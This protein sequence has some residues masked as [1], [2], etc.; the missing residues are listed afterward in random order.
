MMTG[1]DCTQERLKQMRATYD[2]DVSILPPVTIAAIIESGG[3]EAPVKFFQA[4]LI[5]AWH[6]RRTSSVYE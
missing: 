3:F 5:H 1:E 2:K 6:A 4:G